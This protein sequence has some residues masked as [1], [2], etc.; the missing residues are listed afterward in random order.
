MKLSARSRSALQGL[1]ATALLGLFATPLV[2]LHLGPRARAAAMF[3]SDRD[4]ATLFPSSTVVYVSA[5]QLSD[6]LE[7]GAEHPLWQAVR[8][9]EFG[10]ALEAAVEAKL[11][12]LEPRLVEY[13]GTDW[14][15]SAAALCESGVSLGVAAGGAEP[16]WALALRA[17]DAAGLTRYRERALAAIGRQFG[18]EQM[19]ARPHARVADADLWQLGDKLTVAQQGA[20]LVVGSQ[21]AYVEALL[22]AAAHPAE[23]GL[24][25]QLSLS[26]ALAERTS[27]TALF[28]WV[29][30]RRAAEWRAQVGEENGVLKLRAAARDPRAVMLL[31]PA[32]GMC[33]NG[34]Q[35]TLE[36]RLHGED[37]TLH[38][39][40]HGAQ[41]PE[42]LLDSAGQRYHAPLSPSDR[43]V[44]AGRLHRDYAAVLARRAQLF[45]VEHL[46][47]LAKGTSDLALLFMGKD[48]VEDVLPRVSPWWTIVA[49]PIDFGTQPQPA[50]E[51]PALAGVFELKDPE[52]DAPLFI[53]A[54]QSTVTLTNVDRAQKG[55][56]AMVL[57]LG[58]E[59]PT[60][61]SA[62]RFAPPARGAAV[63][64]RYNLAPACAQV[65]N[66]LVLGTHESLVRDIVREVRDAQPAVL[67]AASTADPLLDRLH[68]DGPAAARYVLSNR[69]ALVLNAMLMEGKTDEQAR[70][71]NAGLVA[72]L[73]LI[74]DARF[75]VRR[76]GERTD[77][78]LS[79][80]VRAAAPSMP[81]PATGASAR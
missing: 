69:E 73:Q 40:V 2:S 60:Q 64:M 15:Q 81:A 8:G 22:G 79:L 65:G 29:D 28:A 33:G 53:S 9:A 70:S 44:L 78:E 80:D 26:E 32:L 3:P 57:A 49:R 34:E 13:L 66:L 75:D 61:I 41:V 12:E 47:A 1:V 74:E 59:G 20:L 62:A 42:E 19:L 46:P 71:E 48:L 67:D 17:T 31:G 7:R 39:A 35:L 16:V 25:E 52:A 56:D 21:R 63:D 36:L 23:L 38:A 43:D 5:P 68:V 76:S 55:E 54:F 45:E 4:L 18:A 14:R 58:L 10:P 27:E 77:L 51:L 24:L 37:P 30:L 50:I 11:A 6:W 72:L